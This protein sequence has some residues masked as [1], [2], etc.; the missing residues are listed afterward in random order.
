MS[1]NIIV[2][3]V[4]QDM[5]DNKQIMEQIETFFFSFILIICSFLVTFDKFCENQLLDSRHI[6]FINL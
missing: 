1:C 3:Y 4:M 6:N 5:N 2:V